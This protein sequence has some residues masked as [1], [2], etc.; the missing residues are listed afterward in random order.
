MDQARDPAFTE[1]SDAVLAIA[2]E[3]SLEPILQRM[4]ATA[5]ELARARYA[6]LGI[7]DGAGGFVRFITAGLTD[8]EV[9]RIGPLPRTHG[10]L[11]AM[12]ESSE[13]V[14]T[15]DIK[16]HPRYR[17][18][19]A[20]HPDMGSFLG[21][22]VVSKERVIA[23]FYLTDRE[24]QAAF[25][26]ADQDAIELLAAHAAVAIENARSY[27]LARE[28]SVI[29]ERN[30]LARE[31]HDS[32]TQRLFSLQLA[33]ETA[34]T[35][36]DRDVEA[37][38]TQLGRVQEMAREA[39]AELRAVIFELRPATVQDEGLL[40]ALRKHV[41]VLRRVE[42]RQISFTADGG[43]PPVGTAV[44]GEAFRIAQEALNNA[45]R[46]SGAARI[47]VRLAGRDGRLALEVGDDGIGFDPTS[48]GLRSR[49]LGLTS[50]EERADGLG[51]ALRVDSKAGAGTRVTLEVPAR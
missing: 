47:W 14:R 11:G 39:M 38:R 29:E 36:L 23:A 7:P 48:A 33:A 31:L 6:A 32:V 22:P 25:S 44:E 43:L 9:A 40:V 35:V 5:R 24:G 28:L 16:A 34:V 21:V 51:G 37:A 19:P 49:R 13:P 42:Q 4:V 18:W 10:L 50:M 20:A 2:A 41:D 17:W 1:L 12:L 30:R 26:A 46:H 27:D 8:E 15:P 45:L 3:R